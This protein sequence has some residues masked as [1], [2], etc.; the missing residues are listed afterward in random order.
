MEQ[1]APSLEDWSKLQGEGSG[2]TTQM[3]DELTVTMQ[4]KRKIYEEAKQISTDKYK[5]YAEAEG[6][7]VEAMQLAGKT[8]YVV[9]GLGTVY[10]VTKMVVPTPKTIEQKKK[11]FAYLREKH[12]E[13]YFYDK[14]SVNHQTLQGVYNSDYAEATEQGKGDMFQIPGL[15]LP[16]PQISLNFRKEK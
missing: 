7:L 5:D 4:E 10:F 8:K 11:L 6:K 1:N 15:D 16:T 3:L 9:E 2:V 12:G 14:V 13:V